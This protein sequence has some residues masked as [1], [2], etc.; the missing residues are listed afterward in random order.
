MEIRP[1]LSTLMRN[2]TGALLVAIQIALSLAILANA[3]FVVATRLALM[4]RPSGVRAEQELFYLRQRPLEKLGFA[5]RMLANKTEAATLRAVPGVQAVALLNQAPLGRSGSYVG[6]ATRRGQGD[7][8]SV[9]AYYQSPDALLPTLGL[10]L[11]EGRD[12]GPADVQEIDP[13][14]S[15]E[16][17]RGVIVTRALAE[18]LFPGAA[19]VVGKTIYF[20]S[21]ADADDSRIIGVIERLQT[22]AAALG[23]EG[24]MALIAASNPSYGGMYAIRAAP[25]A[26]DQVMRDADAALRK[27]A[28]GPVITRMQT[29]QQDRRE[30]YRTDRALAWM[31]VAVSALLLL[32]TASGVVGIASLWVTQRRRQ[33][34]VRRALGARKIDIMRYF[35]TENLL[36]TSA[37]IGAGLLLALALNQLLVSQLDMQRLSP[38]YP[39]LG[40]ILFWLLGLVAVYG[41]AWRAASIAPASATRGG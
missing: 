5:E 32:V 28:R 14:T 37:G 23:A 36:I 30:R 2:K 39:A 11:L 38:A 26:S 10:T 6:I 19:S 24:E 41:P 22:P 18:A 20:G 40:A 29:M 3:L 34:G 13:D 21:E 16:R 1:I 7:E 17:P 9:A 8:G 15:A 31:L 25:G 27:G 4:D 12:F 33:I 35:L